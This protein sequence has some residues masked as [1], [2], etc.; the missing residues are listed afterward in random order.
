MNN[1]NKQ[2]NVVVDGRVRNVNIPASYALF[3]KD[4]KVLLTRRINTGYQDGKYMVPSGHVEAGETFTQALRREIK[5]EVGIDLTNA[6]FKVVHIMNRLS[7]QKVPR[8]DVFF[9]IINWQ[10]DIINAEPDLCDQV[11]WFEIDNLPDNT[12]HYLKFAFECIK[13]KLFY[14]EYGWD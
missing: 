1:K 3:I 8:V 5:E 12:V 6:D 10:G 7:G 4:N 11:D 13:Q 2:Y 9:K 14:S